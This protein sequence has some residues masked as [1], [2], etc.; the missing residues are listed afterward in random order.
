MCH[1]ITFFMA[2]AGGEAN[3]ASTVQHFV[4][5]GLVR[6]LVQK[7]PIPECARIVF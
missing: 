3:I 4:G 7:M 2:E 5:L 6:V 1:C